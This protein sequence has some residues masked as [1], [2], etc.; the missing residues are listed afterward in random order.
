MLPRISQS[1]NAIPIVCPG[2]FISIP[3]VQTTQTQVELRER[4]VKAI[5][6]Q[7]KLSIE[8]VN[9]KIKEENVIRK[10]GRIIDLKIEIKKN[11]FMILI[12]P[13]VDMIRQLVLLQNMLSH[14]I[15]HDSDY[16]SCYCSDYRS[17]QVESRHDFFRVVDLSQIQFRYLFLDD[18][19]RQRK[20]ARHREIPENQGRT[21][22][23]QNRRFEK[24]QIILE[25]LK[26][27]FFI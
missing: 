11:R 5:D 6:R 19:I 1:A 2:R 24:F 3:V 26:D 4:H 14:K 7:K 16:W 25:L 8:I 18:K 15:N 17:N 13:E 22:K 23:D 27:A 21:I 10:Y 20:R 12:E 9:A